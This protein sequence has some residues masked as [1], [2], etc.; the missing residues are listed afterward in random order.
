MG[1]RRAKELRKRQ[2]WAEAT[3]ERSIAKL[4]KRLAEMEKLHWKLRHEDWGAEEERT[5]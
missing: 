1:Y 3:V 2:E 5:I 4:R